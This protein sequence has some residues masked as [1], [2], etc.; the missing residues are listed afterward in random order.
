MQPEDEAFFW[1]YFPGRDDF[2]YFPQRTAGREK[3]GHWTRKELARKKLADGNDASSDENG[4]PWSLKEIVYGHSEALDEEQ[5][6]QTIKAHIE[7][8]N[9]TRNKLVKNRIFEPSQEQIKGRKRPNQ[10]QEMLSARIQRIFKSDECEKEL[11]RLH[12]YLDDMKARHRCR[13]AT[14]A[15][16]RARSPTPPWLLLPLLPPTPPRVHTCS[17]RRPLAVRCAAQQRGQVEEGGRRLGRHGQRRG[18]VCAVR[19][20]SNAHRRCVHAS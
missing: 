14:A 13:R 17:D 16:Q 9:M 5:T 7:E 6:T 19:D 15:S 11:Q 10:L 3:D 2:R 1:Q 18:S 12:F 4:G 20:A 8:Y